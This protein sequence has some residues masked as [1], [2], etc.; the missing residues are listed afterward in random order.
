MLFPKILLPS[1]FETAPLST[2]VFVLLS[3]RLR[4]HIYST[5]IAEQLHDDSK[6]DV[7]SSTIGKYLKSLDIRTSLRRIPGERKRYLQWDSSLMEKLLKRYIPENERDEYI[8]LFEQEDEDEGEQA[9]IDM[10]I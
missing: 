5:L 9:T 3:N 7:K 4:A 6:I 8:E 2:S 1:D 10:D